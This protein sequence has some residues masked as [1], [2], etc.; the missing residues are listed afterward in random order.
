MNAPE[1]RP[2]L[3]VT[4]GT[5]HHPFNRLVGWIDHWLLSGGQDRVR[6]IVQYCSSTPPTAAGG[7][8]F[9]QHGELQAA[10]QEAAIVVCHAGATVTE[11]RQAGVVPI[12]VPRLSRFGEVVDDHQVPFA[13]RLA[14]D[15]LVVCCETEEDLRAAIEAGLA[16]PASLRLDPSGDDVRRAAAVRRAGSLIDAIVETRRPVARDSS[17]VVAY[18]GGLGRSGSTLL[19][20]LLD[21]LPGVTALGEVTHMWE[22][23]VQQDETCGCGQAFHACPFWQTVGKGAFGGWAELDLGHVLRTRGAVDRTRHIPALASGVLPRSTRLA[24]AQYAS[25]NRAVHAAAAEISGAS[26]VIDS[27]KRAS[28]AHA[29]HRA[30]VD[31]RV[32]HVVRDPRGVAHSWA[33]HVPRPEASRPDDLMPVYSPWQSAWLWNR[34]NALFEALSRSAPTLR[35]RYEDLVADPRRS[36]EA[37]ATFLGLAPAAASFDFLHAGGA[38]LGDGHLVAG[39]PMRFQTGSVPIRPDEGWRTGLPARD[40]RVVSSVTLPLRHRYGYADAAEPLP[41]RA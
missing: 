29:L 9:L 24:L 17:P 39:N 25:Y 13:R 19:E 18:L 3:L 21:G 7:V 4:T 34:E 27:S 28:L 14:E 38:E 6:P 8:P 22:R 37:V 41:T 10:I 26:V 33:K 32:V 16:A 30:G 23:G 40:R 36:L 11:C 15:G 2:L 5:D 12:V 31:L 1:A 20:R 35:V